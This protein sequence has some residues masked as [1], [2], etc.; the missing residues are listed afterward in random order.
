MKKNTKSFL[1]LLKDE[2]RQKINERISIGN[3]LLSQKIFTDEEL[4]NYKTIISQW[5]DYNKELLK[6]SFDNPDNE[7]LEEYKNVFHFGDFSL[8]GNPTIQTET[9]RYKKRITKYFSYLEKLLNKLD[10]IPV[11]ETSNNARL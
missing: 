7:Y 8:G 1:I 4:Q 10:L 6:Q 9:E 11:K 2:F 5:I 3:E